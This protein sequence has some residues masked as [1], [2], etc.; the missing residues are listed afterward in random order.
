MTATLHDPTRPTDD[1]LERARLWFD[2]SFGGA[3]GSP[4]AFDCD[5]TPWTESPA[6]WDF[7]LDGPSRTER[8]EERTL[9]WRDPQSGLTI[10]CVALLYDD[11]PT[12]EWTAYVRND[13]DADAPIVSDL[14][15]MEAWLDGPAD[16]ECVF[17][18]HRGSPC[19]AA[20]Y[21]PF[22]TPMP[23]GGRVALAAGGGR[24]TN[25]NMSY[26]NAEWRLPTSS[27]DGWAPPSA[28]LEHAGST[29]AIV[30][31]GWPGQW[32][33]EFSRG[34][35][36]RLRVRAGQEQTHFRL[37]PGEEIRTP[38]V[39][40]QF[41]SGD[42]IRSQNVWRRWMRAHNSPMSDGA[43]PGPHFAACGSHQFGEMIETDEQKQIHHVDRYLEEGLK[44][45]YW[46]MDAG[47]YVNE[48]GWPHVGTWEV[49]RKRFPRGLR[50][51]TDHTHARDVKSIVWFEPERVTKGTWL[52]EEH[53]EWLLGEGDNWL[54]D[55]GNPE[56]L[57]WLTEHVD[58]LIVS[59]G[60]DLYRQDFN[61]DP[62]DRWRANDAG[63]RQ[64]I[65]ENAY[66]K[67]LLAFW[68]ELQRR[69]PGMTIDTCASGGRRNDVETLRRA[70]PLHRSDCIIE[71]LSQQCHT[72]G[73]SSWIPAHGT[74]TKG[75]DAYC[76]RS[77]R[78][79][80]LNA[81]WDVRRDD[82]DYDLLRRMIAEWRRTAE[83]LVGDFY[84]L[85]SY[86]LAP[87]AWAA[88][89]YDRPDLG[90]GVVQVFRR[91]DSPLESGR[92][93][94]RGVDPAATYTV[95]DMDAENGEER[96][97]RELIADGVAVT[98]LDQPGSAVVVYERVGG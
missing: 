22:A 62:L 18:H 95:T 94:L 52:F 51:I 41:W 31:I 57:D 77:T 39:V 69:H 49:D 42:R 64:G 93:L 1:E 97:G 84:P 50:A 15:A 86:S 24:S 75:E 35:D 2:A 83:Y 32:A 92:F 90:G 73:I 78:V 17:H 26:F 38:L 98:L 27:P 70:I 63:D 67:G 81:V 60:I 29:G 37:H 43:P 25:E 7:D 47:W 45:D 11:F 48:H 91:P 13:G 71:P 53:P 55:L 76:L 79:P 5:G 33:A 30:A 72:F 54:L 66:V 16:A 40:L 68:D 14:M 59:E 34:D 88:W 44:I 20:D 6:G 12:V 36:G 74:G 65:T 85:I 3:D 89:Q 87:D 96:T 61:T 46:W 4:I 56:A 19:T 58:G 21:E 23:P 9:V 28:T 10:R 82:L 8:G 80:C